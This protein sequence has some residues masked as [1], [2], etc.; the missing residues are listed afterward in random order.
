[1]KK[2]AILLVLSAVAA[3]LILGL[4]GC[5]SKEPSGPEPSTATPPANQPATTP[6]VEPTPPEEPETPAI[7][8]EARESEVEESLPLSESL[9]ALRSLASYRYETVMIY[10]GTGDLEADSGTLTILGEYAAP[11]RYHLTIIDSAEGT[12]TEFIKIGDSLWVY[13]EGEWEEVPEAAAAAM[14]QAIF[15]FALDFVWGTLAEGLAADSNYVGKETVNGV[16]ALH[17][18]STSS[19]WEERIEAGFEN[20]RGDIWIAEA[21][22]PVRFVFT[23]SGTDEEGNTG[24]VEWR[25]DVTDVN[26][27]VT[28]TPPEE[29]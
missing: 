13:D 27:E 1:M 14:S 19:V 3:G 5:G 15:T 18:S 11:D 8:P 7:Q 2:T 12:Q 6:T 26:T 24:S 17:Y 25:T 16:R 28:I 22:Y 21:G 23:A 20:A 29:E 9:A 4:A 10:E